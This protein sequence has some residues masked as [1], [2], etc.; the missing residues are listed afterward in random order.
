MQGR[1]QELADH[2]REDI[3]KIDEPQAEAMFETAAEV[4]LGLKKAFADYEEK[5]E[6]AWE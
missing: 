5:D 1:L 4:L 6:A 2:L 3:R